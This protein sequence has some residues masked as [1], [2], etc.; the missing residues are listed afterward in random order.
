MTWNSAHFTTVSRRSA[1]CITFIRIK[2][3]AVQQATSHNHRLIILRSAGA[4]NVASARH[5]PAQTFALYRPITQPVND[6]AICRCK[7]TASAKHS[8]AQIWYCTQ[9]AHADRSKPAYDPAV[10]RCKHAAAADAHLLK[11]FALYRT[12]TH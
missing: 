5:S 2:L 9:Q 11:S 12:T 4:S 10:C 6:T 7:H 3:I 8:P 1:A